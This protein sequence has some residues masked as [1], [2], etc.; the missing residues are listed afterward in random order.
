MICMGEGCVIYS[1]RQGDKVDT[2]AAWFKCTSPWLCNQTGI[3]TQMVHLITP[4]SQFFYQ[5]HG[6]GYDLH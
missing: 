1:G 3:W 6:D 4:K 2:A 5:S